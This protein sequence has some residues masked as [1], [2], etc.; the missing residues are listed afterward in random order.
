VSKYIR[1]WEPGG[2]ERL[3]TGD[4]STRLGPQSQVNGSREEEGMRK[5]TKQ[6]KRTVR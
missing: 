4:P 2:E 3:R 1:K 6:K 5:L